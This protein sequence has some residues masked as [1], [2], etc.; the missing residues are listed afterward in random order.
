MEVW[1][2]GQGP[3][4][5]FDRNFTSGKY[6]SAIQIYNGTGNQRFYYVYPFA[7]KINTM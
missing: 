5:E 4:M 2:M 1:L 3:Q 6:I 7:N